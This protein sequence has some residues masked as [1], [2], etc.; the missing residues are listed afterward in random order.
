MR[1][2]IW[3]PSPTPRLLLN[4]HSFTHT[5]T[6][7]GSVKYKQQ[8]CSRTSS[9]TWLTT[10]LQFTLILYFIVCMFPIR[11]ISNAMYVKYSHFFFF[12]SMLLNVQNNNTKWLIIQRCNCCVWWC[13]PSE[14]CGTQI[15]DSAHSLEEKIGEIL[16][17]RGPSSNCWRNHCLQEW[18]G[19]VLCSLGFWLPQHQCEHLTLADTHGITWVACRY[20]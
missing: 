15:W 9:E 3:Y 1:K 18:W 8:H 20:G 5:V 13:I 19:Q 7:V 11:M 10:I 4:A 12:I 2:Q 17:N 6:L 14:L 16:L